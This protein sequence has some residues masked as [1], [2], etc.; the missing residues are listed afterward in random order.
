MEYFGKC[1][2]SVQQLLQRNFIDLVLNYIRQSIICRSDT[3]IKCCKVKETVWG[4][5]FGLTKV[6]LGD[7]VSFSLAVMWARLHNNK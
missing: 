5:G 1:R 4:T 3:C 6:S 7:I 2:F